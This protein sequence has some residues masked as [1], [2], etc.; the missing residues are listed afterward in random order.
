MVKV[1]RVESLEKMSKIY[2]KKLS[3]Y[4]AVKNKLREMEID[5]D[6]LKK[7]REVDEELLK[8]LKSKNKSLEGKLNQWNKQILDLTEELAELKARYQEM[9]EKH[10][11]EGT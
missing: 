11:V 8:S 7:S 5:N 6:M 1:A 9:E 2:E 10:L 4:S 3:E